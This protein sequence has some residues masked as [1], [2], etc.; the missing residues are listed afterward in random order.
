MMQSPCQISDDSYVK[1]QHVFFLKECE[2]TKKN[3][4]SQEDRAG[5]PS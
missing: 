1:E 2:D 3:S 4:F 5:N